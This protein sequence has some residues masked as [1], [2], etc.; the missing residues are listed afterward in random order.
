[1]SFFDLIEISNKLIDQYHMSYNVWLKPE[2]HRCS[3]NH[4]FLSSVDLLDGKE[5]IFTTYFDEHEY[6]V[7]YSYELDIEV[8]PEDCD[9]ELEQPG[10]DEKQSE[11][12]DD[13]E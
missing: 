8:S 12:D 6:P 1:M 9:I 11:D 10:D 7:I 5:K 13:S 2:Y 3:I 4:E